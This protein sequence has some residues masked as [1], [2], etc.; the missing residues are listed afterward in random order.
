MTK[1]QETP[2][3]AMSVYVYD[4][5]ATENNEFMKIA[6]QIPTHFESEPRELL[7]FIFSGIDITKN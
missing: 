2:Q 3:G 7:P 6:E 5:L 1:E 4:T